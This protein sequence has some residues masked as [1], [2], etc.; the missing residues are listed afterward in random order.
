MG[1]LVRPREDPMFFSPTDCGSQRLPCGTAATLTPRQKELIAAT[2]ALV[3]PIQNRAAALFYGRL[4]ELDPSLRALFKGNM[5]EQG[6]KLM[7][8][9]AVAVGS[10]DRLEAIIPAL[11]AL[12][13]RHASYGVTDGHY[14]TVAAALMWTR[15]EMPSPPKSKRRGPRATP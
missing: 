10:L 15:W 7:L 11:Q 2:F 3:A 6:R 12:G 14:S 9:L 13:Q 8:M 1:A 4:F 5:A